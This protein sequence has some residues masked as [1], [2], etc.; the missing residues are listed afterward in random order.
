VLVEYAASFTLDPRIRSHASSMI[1]N[2][3]QYH[4]SKHTS[5]F[6]DFHLSL[7]VTGAK[8]WKR[9]KGR[10][11]RLDRMDEIK[12]KIDFAMDFDELKNKIMESQI[13][14]TKDW[15]KWKWD[16]ISDLIEGPLNN[17]NLVNFVVSKTKFVKRIVSF[18]RPS[19]RIFCKLPWCQANLKYVRMACQLLDNLVS[20]DAGW[21]YF[22]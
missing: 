13:T 4:H 11:R 18:L 22:Q 2:L 17:P 12:L 6:Y 10:D 19:H 9:L 20:T 15:Q 16:I 1:T 21:F 5:S 3:H 14:Q 7:I 8:K